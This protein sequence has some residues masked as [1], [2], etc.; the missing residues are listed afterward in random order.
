MLLGQRR[1]KCF[2]S[3]HGVVDGGA[4]GLRELFG[5]LFDVAEVWF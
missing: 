3:P 4:G 2:E 5:L 1:A